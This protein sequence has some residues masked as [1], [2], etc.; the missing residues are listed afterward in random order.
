MCEWW[1]L[2]QFSSCC[3]CS[4][5]WIGWAM[6]IALNWDLYLASRMEIDT[7]MYAA[8]L[9]LWHRNICSDK[10]WKE[11]LA[12]RTMTLDFF[13]FNWSHIISKWIFESI[14]FAFQYENQQSTHMWI[15]CVWLRL[16]IDWIVGKS[17]SFIFIRVLCVFS[18]FLAKH[19]TIPI[20]LIHIISKKI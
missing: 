17:W 2:S 7:C 1:I 4:R 12:I 15:R 14:L 11:K 8:H 5:Y 19:E 18:F 13:I 6:T 20:Q 16:L 10:I 9:N 3:N